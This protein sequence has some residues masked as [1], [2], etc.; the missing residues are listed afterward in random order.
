[1]EEGGRVRVVGSHIDTHAEGVQIKFDPNDQ[2]SKYLERMKMNKDKD[3]MEI[4][5]S[6]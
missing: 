3:A 4:M 6:I 2:I 1:M 5:A